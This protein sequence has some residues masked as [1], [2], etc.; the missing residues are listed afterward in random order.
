MGQGSR[1]ARQ[2]I[3]E[4]VK[5]PLGL[6]T[7]A[8]LIVEVLFG[9]LVPVVTGTDRTVLICAFVT[10]ILLIVVLV[11]C[12]AIF[13]PEALKGRRYVDMSPFYADSLSEDIHR[14]LDSVISNFGYRRDRDQAWTSLTDML[15]N[16]RPMLPAEWRSFREAVAEGIE[17]RVGEAEGLRVQE[18]LGPARS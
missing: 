3:L 2:A 18:T 5:T 11:A 15:R 14:A 10:L 1:N 6:L 4:S 9:A 16:L 13:R 17:R 8:L 7:L 12:I